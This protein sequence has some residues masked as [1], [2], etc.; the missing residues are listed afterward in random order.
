MAE[1][2]EYHEDMVKLLELIWGKDFMSPGGRG[3]VEKLVGDLNLV[4]KRVLDIGCGLGG[5]AFVLAKEYVAHVVGIDIEA[6]LVEHAKQRALELGL[7][8]TCEF[9]H[10]MPGKL[11]FPD[12]SFDLVLSSGAFT[13]VS[14]KQVMYED[15]LR[16]LKPGAMLSCYDWMKSEGEYSDDMLYWFKMEGLSYAMETPDRHKEILE[17]AGFVD[18]TIT[19]ASAWYR[20]RAREEYNMLKNELRADMLRLLGKDDA[21]YFVENWRAMVTVCDK[22]EMLQVYC[23]GQKPT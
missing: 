10:V 1:E 9:H 13:Q 15:C 11:A 6:P 3:N 5:P 18:V 12:N 14:N 8:S 20:Q 19:D 23:R 2:D 21:D 16:I 22:G 4:G 7:D 17:A